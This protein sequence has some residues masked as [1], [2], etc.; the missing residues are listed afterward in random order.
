LTIQRLGHEKVQQEV[1]KLSFLQALAKEEC[2]GEV[3]FPCS[4]DGTHQ[5][6]A[7]LRSY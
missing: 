2:Q 7:A 3:I 5:V 4:P 6:Q 1:E